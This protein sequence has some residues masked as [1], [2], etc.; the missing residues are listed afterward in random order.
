MCVVFLNFK[1]YLFIYLFIWFHFWLDWVFVAV[2]SLSLVVA[3]G[4][5]SSLQCTRF[6]LQCVTAE[7]KLL[8][9][10]P[11][12]RAWASVVVARGL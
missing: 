8:T 9:A 6:S 4:G 3:S 5:C 7:H 2:G 12:R 11:S 1:R 10:M